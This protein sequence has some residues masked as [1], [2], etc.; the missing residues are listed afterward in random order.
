LVD[1]ENHHF[2]SLQHF[3]I[4]D[5]PLIPEGTGL[6]QKEALRLGGFLTPENHRASLC[7]SP[8]Q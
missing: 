8:F 1:L 2:E 7:A 4:S 5:N 6:A 3:P